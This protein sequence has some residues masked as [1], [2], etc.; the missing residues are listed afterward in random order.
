M[1]NRDGTSLL[2]RNG[3]NEDVAAMRSKMTHVMEENQLLLRTVRSLAAPFIC[4]GNPEQTSLTDWL[5]YRVV[6]RGSPP[7]LHSLHEGTLCVVTEMQIEKNFRVDISGYLFLY[8]ALAAGWWTTTW[9]RHYI[10]L[11][12]T[13]LS[14]AKTPTNIESPVT[15]CTRVSV[16]VCSWTCFVALSPGALAARVSLSSG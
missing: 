2:S 12:G 3:H 8:E 10:S 6:C 11:T 15:P 13:L 5:V 1:N 14:Y 4:K 7:A 9:V 16:E